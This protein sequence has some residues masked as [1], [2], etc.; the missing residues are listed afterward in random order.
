MQVG[1]MTKSSQAKD[2]RSTTVSCHTGS[3]TTGPQKWLRRSLAEA[4]HSAAER[5]RQHTGR[6]QWKQSCDRNVVSPK[7]RTI[8][9]NENY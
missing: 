5:D 1:R 8:I 3:K 7:E 2:R 4:T 9:I 6:L